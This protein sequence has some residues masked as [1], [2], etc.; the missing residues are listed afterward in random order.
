MKQLYPVALMDA[1][2]KNEDALRPIPFGE[3]IL[4]AL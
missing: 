4:I 2:R 1:Q 3:A